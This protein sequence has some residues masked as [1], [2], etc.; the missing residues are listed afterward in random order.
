MKKGTKVIRPINPI[1]NIPVHPI[2]G[3]TIDK[4]LK[5]KKRS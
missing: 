1:K 2:E 3:K 5:P 4:M